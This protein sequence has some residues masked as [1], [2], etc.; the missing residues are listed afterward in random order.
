MYNA[1]GN[2][3][4][5]VFLI[6]AVV[7]DLRSR[8]IPNK[9]TASMAAAAVALNVFDAG[10]AGAWF[11]AKGLLAGAALLLIPFA[12]GGIGAGDVK[13]LAAVGALKGAEFALAAFLFAGIAGGLIAGA[14][15]IANKQ[16]KETMGRIKNVLLLAAAGAKPAAEAESNAKKR[17]AIP[18]AGAIALGTLAA[19]FILASN[20]A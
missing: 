4:L 9:L 18:Y 1:A 7:I 12:A 5:T 6:V 2:T 15:V 8:R 20:P 17:R 16:G 11:S 14:S 3:I 10:A 19:M 13:M